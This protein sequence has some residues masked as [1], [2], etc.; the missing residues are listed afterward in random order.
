MLGKQSLAGME[1]ALSLVSLGIVPPP[2]DA[3]KG[4]CSRSPARAPRGWA[5]A[6]ASWGCL[7]VWG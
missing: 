4:L 7:V 1:A 2:K 6:S 5:A 3:D